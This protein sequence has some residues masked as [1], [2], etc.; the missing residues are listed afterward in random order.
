MLHIYAAVWNIEGAQ[1]VTDTN[2]NISIYIL[3]VSS[4]I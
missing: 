1:T 3:L 2:E 4:S